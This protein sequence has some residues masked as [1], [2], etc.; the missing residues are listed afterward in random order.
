MGLKSLY[1]NKQFSPPHLKP[2]SPQPV[3]ATRNPYLATRTPF[4]YV[5]GS[6]YSIRNPQSQIR[7][8]KTRTSQP[9]T[10]IPHIFP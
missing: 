7:N 2:I 6:I 9:A 1:K 3:P 5:I 8:R 10:R 4:P